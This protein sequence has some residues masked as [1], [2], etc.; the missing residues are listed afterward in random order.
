[1]VI[2]DLAA[3]EVPRRR[4]P[5]SPQT[6][7]ELFNHERQ[8]LFGALCLVTGNAQDADDLAQDAFLRVWEHWGRV[9]G[10]DDPTG[11][12]YRTAMNTFRSRYRRSLLALRRQFKDRASGDAI[13][14][15]EERI[16]IVRSLRRLTE[17]QRAAILL[18]DLLEFSSDEAGQILGMRAGTIRTQ[19]SRARAELRRMAGDDDERSS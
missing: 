8:R 17:K 9:G 16:E 3:S 5:A 4:A 15:V 13:A 1:M 10:L 7:E 12:L 6:F 19:A 18:L 14:A 11:Y 2:Q